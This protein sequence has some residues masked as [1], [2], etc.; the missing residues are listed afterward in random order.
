MNELSRDEDLLATC[1]T[2][3]FEDTANRRRL[4]GQGSFDPTAAAQLELADDGR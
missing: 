2:T 1:W 4:C 3:A